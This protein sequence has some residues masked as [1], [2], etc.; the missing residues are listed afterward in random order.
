MTGVHY[1]RLNVQEEL[2][3]A[4]FPSN[5]S[6]SDLHHSF[7]ENVCSVSGYKLKHSNFLF[8]S[9]VKLPCVQL[10]K[11]HAIKTYGGIDV[12]IHDLS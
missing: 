2:M 8:L 7:S 4:R 6:N 9:K 12:Q 1:F 5:A 10:I 11:H 3:R